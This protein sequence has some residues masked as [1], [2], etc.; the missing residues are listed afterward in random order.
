MRRW[1]WIAGFTVLPLWALGVNGQLSVDVAFS[2]IFQYADFG[3]NATGDT[4]KGSVAVDLGLS[5]HPTEEDQFQLTLS[6]A[7]GNGLKKSFDRNG[8]LL[9]PNADDLEDDLKEINGRNRDYL[10]EA[11]YSHTFEGKDW[12]FTP[13]IGI[14]DGT[15]YIDGNEYANDELTQFMNDAFVNNPLAEIPSYDLGA[16]LETNWRNLS[17]VGL[18]MNSKNDDGKS[19]GYYSLQVGL[20]WRST[21]WRLYYYRTSKDFTD[22]KGDLSRKEGIGLSADLSVVENVGLFFR[23]GLNTHPSTGDFKNLYSG[24]AVLSGAV[25]GRKN[26]SFGL[27]MA[28]L[29][30]NSKVSGVNDLSVAEVYYKFSINERVEFTLDYQ[31]QNQKQNDGKLTASVFGVRLGV[32]F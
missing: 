20:S 16:V 30:G 27:G 32:F 13:T 26:D 25:W 24:G 12:S 11:Y 9:T 19:Y 8:F 18:V 3:K 2:S 22:Y 1:L 31:Y 14:I 17:L 5:F 10:L 15:A 29:D 21:N 28:Y 7:G 6:F 23:L 4:S